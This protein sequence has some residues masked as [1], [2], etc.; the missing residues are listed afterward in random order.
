MGTEPAV[1]VRA[2]DT[3]DGRL[4]AGMT[5]MTDIEVP[6][7]I[8]GGGPVGLL[9]AQLL[10]RRGVRTLIAE[11]HIARLDAPKAHAL[12]PRSLEICHAA[13][14]PMDA[15]HAAATRTDDGRFVRMVTTLAA[16]EIGSLPYERQDDAVR[17]LTPWP[18]INIAQPEFEAIVERAVRSQPNVEIRRG[19]EWQRCDQLTD[20]VVSTLV[21]RSTGAHV[22]VRSRYVIAADGA[23]SAVRDA[24]GIQMDGPAELQRNVMIHFEADLRGIVGDKPGILYFLF[25][26][27]PAGVFIAYDIGRTWVLMHPYRADAG[28]AD[29]FDEARCRELVLAAVGAPVPDLVIKGARTWVMSAQVAKRYRTGNVFLA[30]DAGHRFPPTGGLGLNTGVGDIDNL[31]WKIAAVESGWAAPSILDTYQ[32]ERRAIA[33][34][35]MGQSLANAMRLSVLQQALGYGANGTVDVA[36]FAARLSNTE[37]RA[38]VDAAIAYQKEH[39]DSLRLQLG[40]AYGDALKADD[41]LPISEFTPKAVVGAR[42]PHVPLADGGS[43][44]DLVDVQGFTLICAPNHEAWRPLLDGC[45]V[46]LTIVAEGRDFGASSGNWSVRMGLESD[47]ALL[48]RPDGH[49]LCRVVSAWTTDARQLAE[50]I[51]AYVGNAARPAAARST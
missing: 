6:V 14:L 45:S 39:F 7:L 51:D 30:G 13:G 15:I 17:A 11:K 42:L 1:D 35:N 2:D 23:G 33:Q 29:Q 20:V 44:L 48:V 25:G 46:P 43:T 31:T 19:L 10:A 38:K 36:T 24:I 9:G 4:S 22:K 47:G 40:F 34:T 5:G 50:A 3:A 21:E 32:S 26:P 8:V 49:I 27:G 37:A 18:L 12:N 41:V 16:P 28:T